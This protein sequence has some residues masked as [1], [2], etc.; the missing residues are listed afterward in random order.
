LLGSMIESLNGIDRSS[1]FHYMALAP[2]Q[3][4]DPLAIAV[5]LL[6]AAVL[7]VFAIVRV[8]RR[9]LQTA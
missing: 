2:A 3:A 1:I 9:D 5:T 6:V 8:E 7:C 4:A